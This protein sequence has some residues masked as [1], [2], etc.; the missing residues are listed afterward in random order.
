M[1]AK[2]VEAF[3]THLAA[4]RR[5]LHADVHRIEIDRMAKRGTLSLPADAL[6][7]LESE[8]STRPTLGDLIVTSKERRAVSPPCSSGG[9]VP[10]RQRRKFVN[11]PPDDASHGVT[12][13]GVVSVRSKAQEPPRCCVDWAR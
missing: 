6:A 8:F 5:V 2:D 9:Q 13:S 7:C 4:T 12:R 1:G 10:P 3:L 11:P